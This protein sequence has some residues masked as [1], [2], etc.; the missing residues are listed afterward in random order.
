MLIYVQI[1][2]TEQEHK[3]IIHCV[4]SVTPRPPL[5]GTWTALFSHNVKNP[6]QLHWVWEVL[7]D[8]PWNI[9]WPW[10]LS[11]LGV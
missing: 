4:P 5:L 3:G 6:P 1:T 8:T 10:H 9:H 11:Q 2:H 7:L